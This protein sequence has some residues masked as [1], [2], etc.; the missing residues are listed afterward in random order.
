VINGEVR[1]FDYWE[2]TGFDVEEVCDML[3]LKPYRYETVWLPH[4]AK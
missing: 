4:D 3:A 1:F 2:Q